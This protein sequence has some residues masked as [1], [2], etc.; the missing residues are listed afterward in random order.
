M[1][2]T[3]DVATT[4]TP[5][6]VRIAAHTYGEAVPLTVLVAPLWPTMRREADARSRRPPMRPRMKPLVEAKCAAFGA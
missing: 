4:A 2:D 6:T 5:S 3:T 1:T